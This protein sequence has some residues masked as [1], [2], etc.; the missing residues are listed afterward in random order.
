MV[1]FAEAA[2]W[3]AGGGGAARAPTLRT[4][5][6]TVGGRRYDGGGAARPTAA[7]RSGWP[8][9]RGALNT[10]WKRRFFVLRV[11]K[12]AEGIGGSLNYYK[13]GEKGAALVG[14][15][16]SVGGAAGGAGSIDSTFRVPSSESGR[17][18]PTTRTPSTSARL[19]APTRSRR[20]VRPSSINGSPR[21]ESASR[22]GRASTPGPSRCA[23][24]AAVLRCFTI[25]ASYT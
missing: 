5:V 22:L 9:K 7:V 20:R 12:P 3:P 6:A 24:T 13:R 11:E 1:R 4:V 15:A 17:R 8:S 23:A 21:F 25:I 10:G 19:A 2:R 18:T 16:G 14:A